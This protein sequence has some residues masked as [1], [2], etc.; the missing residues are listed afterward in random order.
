M[1]VLVVEDETP[2]RESLA[3]R[4]RRE[5]FSVDEAG[6]GEEGLY[7]GTEYRPDVAVVDL[8]LPRLP[9]MDLIRRLRD[10]G[11]DFPIL[12]LTAR[13]RW[14]EKVDGLSAGADDYVVKPFHMEELVARV[15]AL[16]RRSGGW[17]SSMLTSG[18]VSVDTRT[19]TVSLH[20]S[21][22]DLTAYEYRVLECLLLRAGEVISK[23]ELTDRLYEQDFDRDSNVIEVFIGRLRRKLDPDGTLTPIET[24]R[25]RGYRWRLDRDS[26]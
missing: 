3:A 16:L 24:L 1:R 20:A 8:G 17:A 12:I 15:N 21:P 13:G 6:D 11:H 23:S 22:V 25:G 10:D 14:E 9:G 4:L 19:Q 5:G 2:L 18:P 7:F 26:G